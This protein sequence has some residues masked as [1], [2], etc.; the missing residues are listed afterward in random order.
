MLQISFAMKKDE[1]RAP[2]NSRLVASEILAAK[3][4]R[5]EKSTTLRSA[6]RIRANKIIE[7]F[8]ADA[9]LIA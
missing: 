3:N 8:Y 9:S 5:H 2:K 1:G 6:G 7:G 4:M